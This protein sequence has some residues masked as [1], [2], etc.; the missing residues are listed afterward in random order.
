MWKYWFWAVAILNIRWGGGCLNL[1]ASN[2]GHL[3]SLG[4]GGPLFHPCCT[5]FSI[6]ETWVRGARIQVSWARPPS[7]LSGHDTK[8]VG[9][10]DH[11]VLNLW[12]ES[13]DVHRFTFVFPI[14]SA[15]ISYFKIQHTPDKTPQYIWIQLHES[16]FW[17]WLQESMF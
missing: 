6:G 14:S 10:W 5:K 8:N 7:L 9:G 4:K 15:F 11:L 17:I 12:T 16:M 1:T 3:V 13:D 2:W